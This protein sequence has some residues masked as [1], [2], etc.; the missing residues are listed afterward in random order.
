MYCLSSVSHLRLGTYEKYLTFSVTCCGGQEAMLDAA[1]R[2]S[3]SEGTIMV[4][5]PTYTGFR[6]NAGHACSEGRTLSSDSLQA[7]GRTLGRQNSLNYIPRDGMK[8]L[9]AQIKTAEILSL[10][11]EITPFA[12]FVM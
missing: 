11:V 4:Q 2:I 3:T 12:L 7:H 8:V 5:V 6:E 1:I 10:A 9:L